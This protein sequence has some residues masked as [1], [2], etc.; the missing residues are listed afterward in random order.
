M[1]LITGASGQ[2][3]RAA[4]AA[5]R[6]RGIA[7]RAVDRKALDITDR[8]A[9]AQM[10]SSD[11]F[12]CILNCAAY[13]AVDAAEDN[14][15]SAFATNA[16]APWLLAS[17]NIPI[18]H[19]STDYV[20]DGQASE[21][22]ST[23]ATTHPLSVYGLSKRAGETALLEGL[24]CGAVV[25]TAWVYSKREGTK[26]FYQTIRRL[27]EKL[28]TL[29]VV[30]DQIGAP[31]LAEDLAEALVTLYEQGAHLQP[32]RVLHFTNA[33][34]C[35][36]FEFACEIIKREKVGC[37]IQPIS[38]AQ[39]PAKALRPHW[40]VLSLKSLEPYGISPRSWLDA[41]AAD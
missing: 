27:A 30:S 12:D 5:C 13:T 6:K 34:Q 1:I 17:S 25:R 22:Y 20:F 8:K 21:P 39:Y 10:L 32:L 38:S 2:V 3:G 15:A 11:A 7:F 41:L 16:F 37:Q 4:V 29:R 23:D 36:W 31:T 14:A 35:S 40:S 26:N 19:I 28:D 24:F 9:L 33:G 18:L